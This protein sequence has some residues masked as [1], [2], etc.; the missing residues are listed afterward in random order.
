M[1]KPPSHS[2][3]DE[4]E[5]G[6]SFR[7]FVPG[8]LAALVL[9]L[10]LTGALTAFVHSSVLSAQAQSFDDDEFLTGNVLVQNPSWDSV[11]RFA[12]EV[13]EPST[14]SGYYA[15]L[16][17][18][19]L[20]L[21]YALGGRPDDLTQFHRSNLGLH[22]LNTMALAVL[23]YV[24]SG[25][26][27]PAMLIGLLF[28]LHPLSVEPI[29]WVAERKT[30]L[31]TF[32]GLVGLLAYLRFAMGTLPRWRWVA[33]MACF[34]ACL[35]KPTAVV[36]PVLML[37]FDGWPLRRL[38]RNA[39]VEKIPFFLMS[40]SFAVVTLVSHQRTVGI[41]VAGEGI[42]ASLL[43]ACHLVVFYL[44]KVV[45]PVDLTSVYL[46]PDPLSLGNPTVAKGLATFLA[47]VVAT[48]WLAVRGMRAPLA[49]GLFFVLALAPTLGGLR[50]S[51]VTASDKYVYLPGIGLAMVAVWVAARAW[52][53]PG[54]G[55]AVA[56]ASLVA[57]VTVL[58]VT[59]AL[60]T[61]DQITHWRDT[62][63]LYEHMLVHTPDFPLLHLNLGEMFWRSGRVEEA[64]R[65]YG[66]A[67]ESDP[68]Y[69][70][71]HNNLG[72]LLWSTRQPRK[73][74]EHLS[75]AVEIEP[76]LAEPHRNLGIAFNGIGRFERA[77]R[78]L[79]RALAIDAKDGQ[80]HCA[81]ALS[82]GQLGRFAEARKHFEE[83]RR[84]VSGCTLPPGSL[85]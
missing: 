6:G 57:V 32:F 9:G 44:T 27:I 4:S 5:A 66:R 56:R 3:S 16:T 28:G 64:K 19:S 74:I 34:F 43:T 52:D 84:L 26:L 73:A 10:F 82:L 12:T 17:M 79:E 69:A 49:G 2:R 65:H 72:V 40:A 60:A 68:N 37:T 29:A 58:A 7:G 11:A 78:E 14:V 20:M 8:G 54:R 33:L 47:L 55:G 25:L 77:I 42:F 13:L 46:L 41:E 15:P 45:W 21:D 63:T 48:L 61:R 70:K 71:A 80:T 62:E 18:I 51:W 36:L 30:L 23:L 76:E 81:Y 59:E 31:A 75:R 38:G 22:V 50:Y 83:S 67:L 1:A 39:L 35:S 53:S 85:G 24:L